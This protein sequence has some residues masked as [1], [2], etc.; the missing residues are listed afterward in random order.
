MR[1]PQPKRTQQAGSPTSASRSTAVVPSVTPPHP[2]QVRTI[3]SSASEPPVLSAA[4]GTAPPTHSI[5]DRGANAGIAGHEMRLISHDSPER[6]VDIEGFDHH[7][8]TRLRLG[9][10]GAVGLTSAGEAILVFHQYASH[11]IS[12]S[13]HSSLQ[14]RTVDIYLKWR[15][16]SRR[17][18]LVPPIV[19]LPSIRM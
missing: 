16:R 13:I 9:T 17:F 7:L 3:T 2:R 6:T 1:F 12:P 14:P 11:A 18:T 19:S 4:G 8:T 5:V 15:E 10:H